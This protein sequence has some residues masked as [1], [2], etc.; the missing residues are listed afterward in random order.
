MKVKKLHGLGNHLIIDAFGCNSDKLNNK[1]LIKIFLLE[2]AKKIKMNVIKGPV[3]IN[4]NPKAK[5]ERGITGFVILAESHISIHTYPEKNYFNTD[6]FSCNEFDVEKI[7][8]F[9]N[10]E[11]SIKE[12]KDFLIKREFNED[13]DS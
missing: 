6:I 4:Y 12:T 2:L 13:E 3:V 9:L 5:L 8:E 7:K 10:E 11:F 1:N